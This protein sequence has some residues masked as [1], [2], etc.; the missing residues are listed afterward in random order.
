MAFNKLHVFGMS[1]FRK[2][3]WIDADDFFVANVDHLMSMPPLTGAM[4][5]AC[6][7]A[8]GP[9][10]AGGGIW[11]V[12]PSAALFAKL[13]DV[14]AKPRP[15]TDEG[16]LLGDMQVVRHV[17]GDAPPA[18]AE[19]PLYPAINDNR[20]G[21]V[22]GLRYFSAFRG[23]SKEAFE[24]YMDGRLDSRKPRVEGYDESKAVAGEVHWRA[25]DMRYDQCV[26][27]FPPSPERDEPDVM[28]SVHFSCLQFIGKP[29]HYET[30]RA[31]M[32]ALYNFG[33]GALL[34]RCC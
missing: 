1:R 17:F 6:I 34:A 28:F 12:E 7:N 2:L 22:G 26:G 25:L 13:M 29:S 14:I 18:N 19:E 4:V 5:T 32:D 23:Y 30:E 3:V 21:Y 31:Y 24:G 20:H 11:V 10:Y 15:G 8:N 27:N 33:D 16:W 9:A